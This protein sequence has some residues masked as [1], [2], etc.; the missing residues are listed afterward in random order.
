M[1]STDEEFYY[2]IQAAER[3]DLVVCKTW[4]PYDHRSGA[5]RSFLHCMQISPYWLQKCVDT[6]P[7]RSNGNRSCFKCTVCCL[8]QYGV[9]CLVW[10]GLNLFVI[11]L[12]L[13]IGT[14]TY[15]SSAEESH[16]HFGHSTHL[17][18]FH[19]FPPFTPCHPF[20]PSLNLTPLVPH[21]SLCVTCITFNIPFPPSVMSPAHSILSFTFHPFPSTFLPPLFTCFTP[22]IHFL[23]LH[24]V[25]SSFPSF[26]PLQLS[27]PT[28]PFPFYPSLSHTS[29]LSL[30]PFPSPLPPH[31]LH[32]SSPTLFISLSSLFI[33][34]FI[35]YFSLHHNFSSSTSSVVLSPSSRWMT[36][37]VSKLTTLVGSKK[38]A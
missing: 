28:S 30:T 8:F 36:G 1:N 3:Y 11:S 4:F 22:L 10:L 20:Y 21:H 25:H 14:V 37:W 34:Q 18:S 17:N 35:S 16:A 19:S 23:F 15:V 27:H 24:L 9:W 2:Y 5:I 7:S 6:W 33:S 32:L 31:F 29:P 38:M 13:E 12:Y 26:Y